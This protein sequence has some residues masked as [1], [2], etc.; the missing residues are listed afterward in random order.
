MIYPCI[1]NYIIILDNRNIFTIEQ[2]SNMY[3]YFYEGILSMI[4]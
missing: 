4:V 1:D 3:K 2:N